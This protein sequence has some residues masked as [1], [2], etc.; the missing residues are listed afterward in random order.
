[1]TRVMVTGS[2][3]WGVCQHDP[4][5]PSHLPCESV[6]EQRKITLLALQEHV[7]PLARTGFVE[8]IHGDSP[9]ADKMVAAYWRFYRYGPTTAFPYV[10]ERLA[11][12]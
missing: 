6:K 12:R 11:D 3:T 2:R 7:V 1:M 10:R 4:Q 9:G 8:L 5:H